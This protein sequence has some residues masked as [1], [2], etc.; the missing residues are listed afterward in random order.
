MPSQ[1]THFYS[2]FLNCLLQSVAIGFITVSLVLTAAFLLSFAPAAHANGA[3]A[4]DAIEPEARAGRAPVKVNEV[5]QGSLLFR[6][7]QRGLY[8]SA[9]A[10]HTNVDMNITAMTARVKVSQSFR[11]QGQDWVEGIYVF[12]LPE[13]AA[14]DHMRMKIG[15]RLIEGRIKEREQA[16][17]IYQAARQTGKRAALTEQER[18]NIFTNSVANIGPG[19]TVVIEIE[20]Q[21]TVRYA[22]NRFSIRFPMVVAPRFIPGRITSDIATDIPAS[23]MTSIQT[24]EET[25][26]ASN[27]MGWSMNTDQV[28]DASRI[29]PPV[30]TV[31]EPVVNP[32]KFNINLNAGID[33][34][35]ITSRYHNIKVERQGVGKAR[36]ELE[37]K[38]VAADRDFVLQW[39]PTPSQAPRAALFT[40]SGDDSDKERQ[41]NLIMLLPPVIER[42]S[43]PRL[44]RE[45]TFIIDTSGS[46]GGQSITQARSAL[47]MAVERLKSSD[48]F[49]IIEFNSTTHMLYSS[50]VEA[51]AYNRKQAIRYIQSLDANGGTV[52]EPAL[53]SALSSAENENYIQQI[54]FLTD[55]AVGNESALFKLI[56]KGLGSKRLFT[57]GIGSASNSHF[58]MRAASFG[59]GTFTYIGKLTEVEEKM[60]A[61]FVKL[62]TPAISHLKIDWPTG[63]A[64]I[65]YYPKRLPDLYNG[66]PLVITAASRPL[67]GELRISGRR[68]RQAWSASLP[69]INQ[70][71]QQGVAVLWARSRI[72]SLMDQLYTGGDREKIK[73]DIIATALRHHLVSKYTSLVAVDV[74]PVRPQNLQAR[75]TAVPTNLP[76]GW[77]RGK[78]FAVMP[79]TATSA[80]LHLL[81]GVLLLLF[82]WVINRG[83]SVQRSSQR[84]PV[85]T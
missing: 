13:N 59:R 25:L 56:E 39:Q 73:R 72:A 19:E 28:P 79:Q 12:P 61:L 62:E 20:Y 26:S 67:T 83:F 2:I 18:P 60:Q 35:D 47:A 30:I 14:V 49:N 21:Q 66:E 82:A 5:Q 42:G 32:V 38:T 63:E 80:Q 8:R 45:V 54:V 55:G 50:P 11:N 41:Y 15:E 51:S 23:G 52:M 3:I 9:P 69:L 33:L 40:E 24:I 16:K 22:D 65:E 6:T 4:A 75:K 77:D 48:R 10:L 85:T 81:L 71:R 43:A 76:D 44:P 37:Q 57:I 84:I 1:S 64:E 17:K 70:T 68:G 34:A 27:G 36:I 74:T 53:R 46:M 31:D 7:D 58:M 29:T 78:V